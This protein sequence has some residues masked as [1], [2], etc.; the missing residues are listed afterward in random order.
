MTSP[1]LLDY[2]GT[3]TFTITPGDFDLPLEKY[4][5]TA[6]INLRRPSE[7]ELK[8]F[9]IMDITYKNEWKPYKAPQNIY[10]VNSTPIFN[11]E[12]TIYDDESIYDWLLLPLDQRI[13]ELYV[14]KPKDR[15]TTEYLSQ[16]WHCGLE[17]AKQTLAENTCKNYRQTFR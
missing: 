7:E 16:I 17:T 15:L 14:L 10:A 9:P 1:P 4:V 3:V 5:L 11:L 13:S 12:G 2:T 8:H 6:Y